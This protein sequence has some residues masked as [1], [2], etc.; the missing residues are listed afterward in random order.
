MK[1]AAIILIM[2][3]KSSCSAF[4][5]GTSSIML[6]IFVFFCA[7]THTRLFIKSMSSTSLSLS[8]DLTCLSQWIKT[9]SLIRDFFP[10]IHTTLFC[11]HR[12]T[13]NNGNC[14]LLCI[15][16][17]IGSHNITAKWNFSRNWNRFCSHLWDLHVDI[18]PKWGKKKL[19]LYKIKRA[20]RMM[21]L[22]TLLLTLLLHANIN[23]SQMYAH[24]FRCLCFI[25]LPLFLSLF[26]YQSLV[27]CVLDLDETQNDAVKINKTQNNLWTTEKSKYITWNY[28]KTEKK[29]T[30]TPAT[31]LIRIKNVS[32]LNDFVDFSNAKFGRI[33]VL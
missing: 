15:F 26:R 19:H 20:V 31:E 16:L 27:F 11:T 22:F 2:A 24:I 6:R 9:Q 14:W 17:T 8:L 12:Y 4:K 32:T 33:S 7:H 30:S 1:N 21:P 5:I 28:N 10:R 23:K 13:F 3:S 29:Q 18:I 25:C